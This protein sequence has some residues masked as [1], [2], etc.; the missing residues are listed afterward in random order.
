MFRLV[1]F[2]LITSAITVVALS[3]AVV[4]YRQQEVKQ[5]IEL[6]ENQ[7]VALA[8]SFANSVWPRFSAFITSASDLD[9]GA[10]RTH[11]T[12]REIHEA[13]RTV[14]GGLPTLKIKIYNLDG[15]TVYSSKPAEI[16]ENKSNNAGFFLAAR[17]GR[18]ASKLT[19]RDSFSTFEG[20]VQDLDLVESYLPIKFDGGSVEGVFELYTDVTPLLAGIRRSTINLAVGFVLV[21]GALYG[22]LFLVVQ[23]ADRIIKRQYADIA[24]KN[25]ALQKEITERKQVEARLTIARDEL[26]QRVEERTQELREEITERKRAEQETRR[27]QNELAQIGAVVI[28]G[29]MATTLAHELNQPLTVISGCAQVCLTKIRSNGSWPEELLDSVVQIAEQAERANEVIRRIRGFV[30]KEERERELI[31]V[32][33]AINSVANLLHADAREHGAEIDMDLD[34]APQLVTADPV[35]IQQV[36]LNLARNGMEAMGELRSA[37]RHLTI[38]TFAGKSGAVEVAVSD[39][40]DGISAENLSR[41]FD[42]FFTTKSDGLGMGLA[43]SRSIIEAH[44]GRLWATSDGGAGSV[45]HFTLPGAV[46]S[47]SDDT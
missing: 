22:A 14:S 18:P 6:A 45:F 43:I 33:E 9:K 24:E 25:A 16:G 40:G 12:V 44:G 26:E 20:T 36:I 21:F 23:R 42:P 30:H 46:E 29:E 3:A 2:F 35:Q 13:V 5:L 8:R 15:L 47:H 31:D 27:H 7:N 28:M 17:K 10:L 32:N 39:K 19:Y 38:Q 11:A 1:R 4:L 34:L 37:T 41:V